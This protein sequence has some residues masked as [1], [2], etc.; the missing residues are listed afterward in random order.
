MQSLLI[1]RG[2]LAIL[3]YAF[4]TVALY[5]MWREFSHNANKTD[6][7]P[8]TAVVI[9]SCVSESPDTS[10]AST[11]HQLRPVTAIGRSSDNHIVIDDP[12]TSTHHA[13][14]VWRDQRW[15]IE[16]LESHNGTLL[17]DLLLTEP[18]VL[19]SGDIIRIGETELKF[20]LTK[21]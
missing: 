9:R 5:V 15:W 1:Y 13:M 14:I 16:D 10:E 8:E 19:T 2:L 12:F 17:N 18:S 6:L 7:N 4:L 3:I 20:T 11:E 21:N